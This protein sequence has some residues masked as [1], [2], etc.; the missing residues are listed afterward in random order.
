METE[1]LIMD[2]PSRGLF[3]VHRS[4]MVSDEILDLEQTHIFDSSWVY[5]GHESEIPKN[6]D[7]IRRRV[8]NRPMFFVRGNDGKPRAFLNTCRHRGAMVCRQE[9]GS[10]TVFQCF[11]HG[12]SYDNHGNLIGVPDEEAYSPAF[13]KSEF[14]LL[15]PPLMDE[16]RGF[17]FVCFDQEAQSLNSYLGDTKI[18]IDMVVDQ[19]EGGV[20]VLPGPVRYSIRANW[21]L[22]VENSIDGYHVPTTHH[23]YT[24]YLKGQGVTMSD[25]EGRSWAMQ[26]GHGH[27]AFSGRERSSGQYGGIVEHFTEDVKVGLEKLKSQQIQRYGKDR[28][29]WAPGRINFLVYPN[30]VFVGKTTIRTIWPVSPGLMEV[31]G[32]AIVPKEESKEEQHADIHGFPQARHMHDLVEEPSSGG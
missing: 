1:K 28:E 25:P 4:T 30:L 29:N 8:A 3:R 6:G 13:E 32:W 26:L 11:Y 18:F 22:L 31:T 23:S 7:F 17:Y 12:W 9:Q 5:L 20:R 10:A 27:G 24:E 19:K 16:Y 2:D 14:G 21:K 15:Q